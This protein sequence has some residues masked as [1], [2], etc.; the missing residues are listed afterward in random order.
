MKIRSTLIPS[1]I[2]LICAPALSQA[3]P[4]GGSSLRGPRS[5]WPRPALAL[6]F[7]APVS[8]DVEDPEPVQMAAAD[9]DRDGNLD[10]AVSTR[11]S[12]VTFGGSAVTV[13]L[14]DGQGGFPDNPAV[15][16]STP[17]GGVAA[18]DFD[19]DGNPDL[20]YSRLSSGVV[21]ALGDGTG[22]F[23]AATTTG[24]VGR[25]LAAA[26]MTGDGLPDLVACDESSDRVSVAVGLGDGTFATPIATTVSNPT[27]LVVADMDQDLV[28]DVVVTNRQAAVLVY[29]GDGTGGLAFA[30]SS[31]GGASF[32]QHNRAAVGDL[33]GD[34][35]PDVAWLTDWPYQVQVAYGTGGGALSASAVVDTYGISPLDVAVAD[36][37]RDGH[38]D[39]AVTTRWSSAWV[40][41]GLGGGAYAAPL[42]LATSLEPEICAALDLDG[43][44]LPELVVGFRNA[45][46]T[47][48]VAV[49]R[50]VSQ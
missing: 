21:L 25:W 7:A 36:F 46:D 37:D 9:F 5:P 3:S 10:V 30:G 23:S 1:L 15:H 38:T 19:G 22:A 49:H 41:R 18:A 43:D 39:L 17:L 13:L 47:P 29:R 45:G 28:P 4:P 26:D 11:G 50:N 2:A 14:G 16:E 6:A 44:L 24:L 42:A 34:G 32:V 33:D 48:G 35:R 27:E 12:Y 40:Y 31:G 20:A 8:F